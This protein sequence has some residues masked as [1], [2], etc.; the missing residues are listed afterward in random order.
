M[1]IV[2][3]L[4]FIPIFY[5]YGITIIEMNVEKSDIIN[6]T[7]KIGN[8]YEKEHMRIEIISDNEFLFFQRYIM[9]PK[10]ALIFPYFVNKCIIENGGYKIISKIPLTYTLFPLIFIINF[11]IKRVFSE[12]IKISLASILFFI[13]FH[14]IAHNWKM[15]FM[16]SDIE[17]F[18]SGVEL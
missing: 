1:G 2:C 18:I 10:T 17:K 6:L 14:L 13:V 8:E 3:I 12:N 9:P 16:L 5:E 15:K 11:I 4:K 7:E